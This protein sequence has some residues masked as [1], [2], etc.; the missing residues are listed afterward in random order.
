LAQKQERLVFMTKTECLLPV[1]SA[2]ETEKLQKWPVLPS[3][4]AILPSVTTW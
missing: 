3:P 1:S 4:C 2:Y